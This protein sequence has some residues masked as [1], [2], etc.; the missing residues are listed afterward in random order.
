MN[1]RK[2]S[3]RMHRWTIEEKHY[4]KEIAKG[5]SYKK[6]TI[7]MNE[8]FEY[9]FT[10]AQI[11]GAMDRYKIKTGANGKFKK[12]HSPWNKGLKGKT[13]HRS[14]GDERINKSGYVEVK[15]P[16]GKWEFKHRLIY[17]KHFGKI[18]DGNYVMFLDGDK[19]NFNIDNLAEITRGQMAIINLNGLSSKDAE[20]NRVGIQVADLM[21]KVTEAKRKMKK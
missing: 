6:I 14:V 20:L 19:T 7:L 4:L 13:G 2:K 10:D 15:M 3:N 12:G 1:N 17:E 8:K 21:M 16:N 9:Q 11:K 5:N 18:K